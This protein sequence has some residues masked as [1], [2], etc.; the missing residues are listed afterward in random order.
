V[1]LKP[2]PVPEP[3]RVVMIWGTLLKS[4]F[5]SYVPARKAT[6]IDPLVALRHE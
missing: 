5:A 4:G 3:N 1:L 2:L 6:T